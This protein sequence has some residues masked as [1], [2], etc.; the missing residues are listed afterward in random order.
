MASGRGSTNDSCT[1]E[2]TS[3]SSNFEEEDVAA[4]VS[5]LEFCANLDDYTPTVSNVKGMYMYSVHNFRLSS[6]EHKTA[7]VTIY[8]LLL[9]ALVM[10]IV[11]WISYFSVWRVWQ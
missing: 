2:Q 10:C 1:A 8:S 9:V 11:V 4:A 3:S 7:L 5:L 6:P